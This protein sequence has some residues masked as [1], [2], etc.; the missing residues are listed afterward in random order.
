[1]LLATA[2][3]HLIKKRGF[4]MRGMRRRATSD[5][6]RHVMVPS[7]QET[8]VMRGMRWRAISGRPLP[9]AAHSARYWI[10]QKIT[11]TAIGEGQVYDAR[12]ITEYHSTQETRVYNAMR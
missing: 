11:K 8:G 3:C 6:A 1:M 7:N 4:K 9:P 10:R 12:C 2:W 5:V